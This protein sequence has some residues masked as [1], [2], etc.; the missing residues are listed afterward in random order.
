MTAPD[1]GPCVCEDSLNIDDGASVPFPHE[2]SDFEPYPCA[3]CDCEAH[4]AP[5]A[6]HDT[7]QD[8]ADSPA[9]ATEQRGGLRIPAE[10]DF[11]AQHTAQAQEWLDPLV[12][13]IRSIDPRHP[14]DPLAVCALA[15][16]IERNWPEGIDPYTVLALAA[17]RL[18]AGGPRLSA[19][20]AF[21]YMR[22]KARR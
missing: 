14:D 1:L 17:R 3:D 8:G 7:R 18:A 12:A 19:R 4:R 16:M 22:R 13:R 20:E 15:D 10:L 2:H 11:T 6:D 5:R 9:D 21:E